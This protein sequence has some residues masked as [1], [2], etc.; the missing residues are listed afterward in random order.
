MTTLMRYFIR[1][2]SIGVELNPLPDRTKP[3]PCPVVVMDEGQVCFYSLFLQF[4]LLFI[5]I[6][7]YLYLLSQLGTF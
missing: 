6:Y 3:I 5:F 2:K 1:I 4:L 7:I